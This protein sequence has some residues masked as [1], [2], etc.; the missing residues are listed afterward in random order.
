YTDL[1]FTAELSL[2]GHRYWMRDH[3]LFVAGIIHTIAPKAKLHLYEVLNP[4]GSA[5]IENVAQTLIKVIANKPKNRP[6]IINCSFMLD[7]PV[8]G[9][10]DEAFPPEIRTAIKNQAGFIDYLIQTPRELFTWVAAQKDV[11]VIAAAGNDGA[12][13]NSSWLIRKRPS[14]RY[15]AAFDGV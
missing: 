14:T 6:L 10:L 5:S 1:S 4:Y 9:V 3:G 2:L 7:I 15:P 8:E 11:S 13:N 12:H